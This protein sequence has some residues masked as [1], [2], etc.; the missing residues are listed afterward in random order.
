MFY[1]E[2]NLPENQTETIRALITSPFDDINISDIA[3]NICSNK[4][5]LKTLYDCIENKR[6]FL[7]VTELE[8][9]SIV[10][11]S[12]EEDNLLLERNE[13]ENENLAY[14]GKVKIEVVSYLEFM[15]KHSKNLILGINRREMEKR[16]NKYHLKVTNLSVPRNKLEEIQKM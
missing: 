7:K 16:A 13:T 9:P 15:V 10:S 8:S 4:T 12:D 11:D 5:K 6:F 3:D 14:I 1:Q 2:T